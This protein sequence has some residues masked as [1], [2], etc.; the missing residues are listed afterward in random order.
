MATDSAGSVD[1]ARRSCASARTRP[2]AWLFCSGGTR[3]GRHRYWRRPSA[4][5]SGTTTASRVHSQCT[6]RFIFAGRPLHRECMIL[7][8]GLVMALRRSSWW[9]SHSELGESA[10]CVVHFVN[11]KAEPV[12]QA[13]QLFAVGTETGSARFVVSQLQA[14]ALH[15][16]RIDLDLWTPLLPRCCSHPLSL[17]Q[18]L[19]S[20]AWLICRPGSSCRASGCRSHSRCRRSPGRR[21]G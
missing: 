3:P 12:P 15:D 11:S 16:C 14:R 5:S 4:L 19:T 8:A 18:R 21:S 6:P 2:Y 9:Q 13:P 17:P 1:A 7:A 10:G 20:S